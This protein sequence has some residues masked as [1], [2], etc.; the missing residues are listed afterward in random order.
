LV[1]DTTR[2]FVGAAGRPNPGG[3]GLVLLTGITLGV[4]GIGLNGITAGWAGSVGN[5][6]LV[7]GTLLTLIVLW[8]RKGATPGGFVQERTLLKEFVSGTLTG[9]SAAA[10]TTAVARVVRRTVVFIALCL[11]RVDTRSM[12]RG[13]AAE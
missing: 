6:M 13:G 7:G 11:S 5:G 9:C 12:D 4:P 3:A 1:T 8:L 2:R 10:T